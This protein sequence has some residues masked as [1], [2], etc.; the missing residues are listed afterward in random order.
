MISGHGPRRSVLFHLLLGAAICF[1]CLLSSGPAWGDVVSPAPSGFEKNMGQAARQVRF[2]SRENGDLVLFDKKGASFY[3]FT[4]NSKK[5]KNLKGA[6]PEISAQK[7]K[8]LRMEFEEASG[9]VKISGNGK[10]SGT[11]NYLQGN[12]RSKWITSVPHFEKLYYKGL[13][14]GITA[15]FKRGAHSADENENIQADF[16][17]RP[18]AGPGRIRL[19]FPGAK[20]LIDKAGNLIISA[21]GIKTLLLKPC[22]Y[23]RES[24][25]GKKDFINGGYALDGENR[26]VFR[27][28][29]YDKN[30]PLVIDPELVFST[31]LGGAAADQGQGIAVDSDGNI[32][33]TGFTF[34][35]DFPVVNPARPFSG[36]SD[37]FIT[38][39]S[40]SPAPHIIYST[41]LGGSVNTHGN[42][43]TID[44]S[45]HAFITGYTD[46][47]DFPIA[48]VPLSRT[49]AGGR[50]I[51]IT[52]LSADGKTLLYST[53]FGGG[54]DDEANG[55]TLDSTENIYVT[56]FTRS[57]N[58]PV[59]NSTRILPV[60][61]DAFAAKIQAGGAKLLYSVLL[62]G[63]S[64][65]SGAAAEVDS[66]GN[67]YVTGST[68]SVDFPAVNARQPKLKGLQ[69]AFLTKLDP[70]GKILFSTF[71]GGSASDLASAIALDTSGNI[72]ITGNTSSTDFP[73][74]NPIQLF[75]GATDAFVSKFTSTGVLV[76]STF[77]G[78]SGNDSGAAIA[79]DPSGNAF[80]TGQTSST[81]FPLKNQLQGLISGLN[82]FVTEIN[83]SGNSFL[84]ST[85]MGGSN[86]D[87]ATAIAVDSSGDAFIT[88][89]TDSADFITK[90][91]LKGYS[92]STDA[93]ISE[94]G[95]PNTPPSAPVLISPANGQTGLGTSVTFTW[96]K[97]TDPDGDPVTYQFSLCT[98]QTFQNC[99]PT[100]VASN[101]ETML[102]ENGKTGGAP[103]HADFPMLLFTA[104][105]F[106]AGKRR[107]FF[108]FSLLIA[109]ALVMSFTVV[110]CG[111]GGQG[112]ASSTTVQ[113]TMTGLQPATTYFWKVVATDG[114]DGNAGSG[115]N[116]FTTR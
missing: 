48:S 61:T 27:V 53:F 10:L 5:S 21:H 96:S 7:I 55:I 112:A 20:L 89:S 63:S 15:V 41:F 35:T 19:Y 76:Y 88:G 28:A 46:S 23:Q 52:E 86:D 62:G 74:F 106:G 56:G 110:S 68:S 57:S 93:F 43:I 34:S 99:P 84:Y 71:H 51:F 11:S 45:G 108:L 4:I 8:K 72:Y 98:D 115:T 47:T 39:I 105:I 94:I 58:F 103:T 37:A 22:I 87:F 29:S 54:D 40:L 14:P 16:I 81:D 6:R 49:L 44:A 77:L 114:R 67:A 80:I 17:V 101:K 24:K 104:I 113:T 107:K 38:K 1:F 30:R 91:P 69:N 66:L 73:V 92:G 42:A 50:D 90:N 109:G 32:Y 3:G 116:S 9:N 70:N 83:A 65:D 31:F 12:D 85:F 33:V 26:A 36:A 102:A 95:N 97:S 78:G 82:A 59:L 13:Y 111:G 60:G 2:L 75:R 79:V 100:Q 64:N 18:G 25:N